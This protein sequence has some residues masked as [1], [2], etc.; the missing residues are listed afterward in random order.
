MKVLKK[1][2]S[3]DNLFAFQDIVSNWTIPAVSVCPLG[4]FSQLDPNLV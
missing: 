1:K 2:T 3:R 4:G